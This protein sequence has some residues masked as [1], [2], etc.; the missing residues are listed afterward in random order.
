ML[1]M[2]ASHFFLFSYIN[3]IIYDDAVK[4]PYVQ[5]FPDVGRCLGYILYPNQGCQL[6]VKKS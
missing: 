1:G 2:S 4:I 6:K 3:F 5:F